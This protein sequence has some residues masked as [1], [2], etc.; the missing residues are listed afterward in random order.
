[1]YIKKVILIFLFVIITG[2]TNHSYSSDKVKEEVLI[3]M[4]NYSELIL[5]YK[6]KLRKKESS[7]VREQLSQAYL[8]FGDPESALFTI[9]HLDNSS[10]S[11]NSFIIESNALFE[12]GNLQAA[13]N[14][15]KQTYWFD[16]KN[17]EIENLI[18]IIYS[19]MGDNKAARV[20]FNLSRKHLYDDVKI[21]NN[22]A[23]LDIIEGKYE[24]AINLL[25]P[26]YINNQSDSLTKSNLMLAVSK[27]GNRTLF[28][29]TF[30]MELTK[31]QISNSFFVLK[32]TKHKF[33]TK[34]NRDK[35]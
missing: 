19:V 11:I 16:N 34:N 32:N 23:V 17:A 31:K 29:K 7:L 10:R 18:G 24:S 14:I 15:A 26:I 25:L 6:S 33:D 1:M 35:L 27:S 28:K 20:Y 3:K 12:S 21:K 30:S 22:I 5:L 4:G 13:L 8:D 9:K 2:C